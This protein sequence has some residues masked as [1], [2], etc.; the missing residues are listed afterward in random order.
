MEEKFK[1]DLQFNKLRLEN[2][3]LEVLPSKTILIETYF[4]NH[5]EEEDEVF[6][7]LG[8]I[9]KCVSGNADKLAT[10]FIVKHGHDY[11]FRDTIEDCS[12]T[13]NALKQ[14]YNEKK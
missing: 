14:K 11:Y 6:Y 7:L 8:F 5:G 13:I 2:C 9:G 1:H 4:S 12:V 3:G 10:S